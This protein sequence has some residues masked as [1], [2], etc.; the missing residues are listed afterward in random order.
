MFAHNK[1]LVAHDLSPCAAQAL[2]YA[3]DLAARTG[4]E[5][6]LLF[7]EVLHGE[8]Y[9]PMWEEGVTPAYL[10]EELSHAGQAAAGGVLRREQVKPVVARDLAPAPAIL[11]YADRHD[12][13]LIAMGTHGR[14]G[15]RHLV[16]GSV[17]EEVVRRAPC[18]V[19]TVRERQERVEAG[20]ARPGGGSP[21]R[22]LVPV[23]FSPFASD[24]VR[25]A[26]A[27][28]A[29]FGAEL[30]LLFVAEDRQVPVFNDT[31]LP[32]F[33]TLHLDDSIVE[34]AGEAL[35]QLFQSTTG[36]DVPATYHVRHG[37]PAKEIVDFAED[38]DAGLIVMGTHGV[39]GLAH[40]FLG[41][42]AERVVRAA[43]CPVLTIRHAE[44][45][46]ASAS[47]AADAVPTP[48]A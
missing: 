44:Q 39:T 20:F 28:A 9:A 22:I 18:P 11:E 13:D 1:I 31:G 3:V 42:I 12:I 35:R 10:R 8:P 23:D 16:L 36:P 37:H 26:R 15:V 45:P 38:F 48:V 7:V 30:D 34:G 19:L 25:R 40:F 5:V 46:A 6:H 47:E 27:L 2:P 33:M 43:P 21:P 4:S 29:L 41:S 17:A 14:R 24:A 32:A